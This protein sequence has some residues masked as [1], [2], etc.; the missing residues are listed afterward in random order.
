MV[1]R[2]IDSSEAWLITSATLAITAVALGAPYL[3]AVAMRPIAADMGGLRSVPSAAVALAM[4]GTGVGG[5]IMGQVAERIGIRLTVLFG[6][7]MVCAGLLLSASGDAWALWIGH[8]LLIGL[9]GNGAI[10]APIFVYIT[11]WFERRRGTGLALIA[12][13]QYMAGAL[14]PPIFERAVENYG[15]R[16]TM[17]GFSAVI[18]SFVLPMAVAFLR[19]APPAPDAT[20]IT[21]AG[22]DGRPRV[23]GLSSNT[24]FFL[25]A[26]A[27]FLCC[28]PMAMPQQ[29]LVAFCGDLGM[30]A[31]SGARML[32]LLLICAF[33]SRQFWGWLSDRIGGSATLVV[34]SLAQAI[35]IAG[36]L[37]TQDEAG[38]YMVAAAFGFGFSGLIPAYILTVRQIFPASQASWRVPAVLMFGMGGMAAGSWLAGYLYDH[39]GFYMPAFATGLAFN[40]ANFAVVGFLL[41]MARRALSPAPIPHGA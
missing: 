27:A 17:M 15:W 14:W 20:T 19:P 11:K 9:L 7:M 38:L 33:I 16:T 28:V 5:L 8:G 1:T 4:V 22:R 3:V 34:C 30:S 6:T 39:F 25:F 36:F 21:H 26:L 32:S 13:G 29:H 31:S 37:M 12:S 23:L 40:I 18:A 10:N 2:G 35:A 41:I 24:A